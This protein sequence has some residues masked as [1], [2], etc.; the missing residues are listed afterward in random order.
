MEGM[1]GKSLLRTEDQRLLE[2]EGRFSDDIFPAGLCW[3]VMVRSPHAH[4]RIRALDKTA[5][6]ASPGVLAVLDG[7]DLLA[8]DIKRIPHNPNQSAPPDIVLVNKDGSDV[9][10]PH[11]HLLPGDKAR[12]VGEAVA[13]VVA[14]TMPQALDAA[15]SVAVDYGVLPGVYHSEDAMRPRAPVVWTEVPDNVAVDTWFG[16]RKA[17]DEAFSRA[18]HVVA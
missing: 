5:A 15:E 16:D 17:T 3:G 8:D 2:G 13:M 9:F 11:Q 12:Y 14:E 6:L 4:A 7:N 1:I 18:A 10:V